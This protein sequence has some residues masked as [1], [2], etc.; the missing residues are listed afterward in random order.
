MKISNA[1]NQKPSMNNSRLKM[2]ETPKTIEKATSKMKRQQSEKE[3]ADTVILS[4]RAK[5]L[6]VDEEKF[7][8]ISKSLDQAASNKSPYDELIKCLEIANRI[9]RGDQPPQEDIH[10]LIEKEPEM[11]SA[12]MLLKENKEDPK[13]YDSLLDEEPKK[14]IAQSSGIDEIKAALDK[15]DTEQRKS[16]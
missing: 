9:A 11:Y 13:Q 7:Q 16:E 3:L 10:F 5:K 8:E 2:R 6:I 15:S 4:D 12:A 14:E 1:S